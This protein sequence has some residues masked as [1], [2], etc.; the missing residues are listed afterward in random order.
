MATGGERR[1]VR[2]GLGEERERAVATAAW[3]LGEESREAAVV[4]AGGHG[5]EA[6]AAMA[7]GGVWRRRRTAAEIWQPD[8]V[9]SVALQVLSEFANEREWG[10]QREL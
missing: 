5:L 9:G 2:R 10:R 8:S 1:G 3:T 6:A 4:T 7:G